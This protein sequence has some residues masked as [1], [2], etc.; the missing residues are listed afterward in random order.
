MNP[1]SRLIAKLREKKWARWLGYAAFSWLTFTV[2]LIATFP[3]Q[4]VKDRVV[5][6]ARDSLGMKL[7]V[8]SAGLAFPLGLSLH[9][10]F[11][12][13]REPDPEEGKGAIAIHV[14]RLTVRPGIGLLFGKPSFSFDA[15][16]WGG[17]LSGTFEEGEQGRK[18]HAKARGI[19]LEKSVLSPLGLQIEGKLEELGLEFEGTEPTKAS[20]TLSLGGSDLLLRGGEVGE[21]ELPRITLG[22][23]EGK[24]A[25]VDGKAEIET[26]RL[27]GR[28][29]QAKA[30][31]NLRLGRSLEQSSLQ[32][33]LSFKPSEDWWKANEMLRTGASMALPSD[34]EGFHS[35]QF[36]GSLSKPRIRTR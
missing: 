30:E 34:S 3:S 21:F 31:G 18:L 1:M 28:D 10:A 6:V 24:L 2:A 9:D 8:E 17:K 4:R 14:D 7:R 35:V 15:K 11:W 13:L 23:L 33:K 22:K 29:L 32:A 26:F 5:A 27:D 20:G 36:F 25:L 16:L 19:D 12:I